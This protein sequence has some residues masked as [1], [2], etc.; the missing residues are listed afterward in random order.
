[1]QNDTNA[2][3]IDLDE[4]YKQRR[5]QELNEQ[6]AQQ[7]NQQYHPGQQFAQPVNDHQYAPQAEQYA[8]QAQPQFAQQPQQQFAQP[9]NQQFAPPQYAQQPQV[10]QYAQ[11]PQPQQYA[12]PPAQPQQFAQQ[13]Q[14]QPVVP[15]HQSKVPEQ[16]VNKFQPP[17]GNA[18]PLGS[19]KDN[20][21]P[22]QPF[23]QHPNNV[24][25]NVVLQKT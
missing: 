25:K 23:E 6:L 11:Q 20:A 10:Q 14:P 3:Q 12:Q 21:I 7:A 16:P 24:P 13:P 8:Q 15:N 9:Q 1:M 18:V 4:Y 22:K 17:A 19:L 2:K 5:Q